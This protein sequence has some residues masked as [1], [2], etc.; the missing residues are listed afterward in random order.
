MHALDWV[1]VGLYLAIAAWIGLAFARRA[2]K[3]VDEFFLS[4]RS[5]PW[6]IAGTSMVAT[7]FSADTPLL[8]SGWVREHG[9]W[10]NWAWW[11]YAISGMLQVFL[12]ARWWRRG[13]VMTKAELAE[14][15]YGGPGARVLRGLLG[16]MHAAVTNTMVLCWV[17]LAAAKIL[18]GILEV[19]KVVAL[20]LASAFALF[21][22]LTSGFWGVVLT[23]LVQFAFAMVGA[24]FLAVL[25]MGAV[26]GI[27]ALHAAV[28]AGAIPAERVRFL[29]LPGAGGPLD[30]SFWT[31]SVAAL[32]VYLG[33]AWWAVENVDGSGF[34]VQRIAASRDERQGLLAV[35]WCNF[36]HYALRPWCWIAVGLASL[37]VLPSLEVRSDVAGI[38][39]SADAARVVVAPADGGEPVA[40]SLESPEADWRPEPVV[41]A[42]A[43]VEAGQVVARTDPESA[44]VVMMRRYLPVGL[45]GMVVAS[46]LAAFM[47]TIDTHVNLAASFF[48]NDLYRR[49][50]RKT[51][52]ERHY[53]AVARI[54][55]AAVL[56]LAA[57]LAWK[58]RSISGLFLFFLGFLG[59]VGP[60]YLLRW[61]WW[62]VRP[63]TEIA[64][65]V[66]SATTA[67]LAKLVDVPWE[68][69]P[70]SPGGVLSDEG[71][72]CVIVLV[73]WSAALLSLALT[74][75]PDPET[76]VPFY[77]RVRP[78]GWWGPV[79]ALV[80]GVR[81]EFRIGEALRGSLGALLLTYGVMLG[82]GF[83]I[84]DAPRA[85]AT[86]TA[87][88]VAGAALISGPLRATRAPASPTSD[89]PA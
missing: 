37:L 12:F 64:A 55:C 10:K 23:D 69:G 13:G 9:I 74:R 71:R 66:A 11:C 31:T 77:T 42:D 33:V 27:D 49:F 29:P 58:S 25:A 65:M 61:F 60:V 46:L 17:M 76:L 6:W 73:S 78:L 41:A 68:L 40:F 1:V 67:T 56:L 16:A 18:Q 53:V 80:P 89:G 26:G 82:L 3:S 22:S 75:A 85:L 19:D 44:Y 20:A 15:R 57:L 52:D 38:V 4:G 83:W 28:E 70:L 59:G 43:R 30:A 72:L 14:L 84:L 88:A 35:L 51:A 87:V 81:S 79:R 45:L 5:L 34:A 48:V 47:S 36:A 50:L 2:G 54:T 62:R 32:A 39:T 7:S 24:V 63:S 8:V 21:Y 86:S